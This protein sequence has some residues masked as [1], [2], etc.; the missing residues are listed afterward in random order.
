[1]NRINLAIIALTLMASCHSTPQ[2]ETSL[3]EQLEQLTPQVDSLMSINNLTGLSIAVIDDYQI[4]WNQE[5]GF[6]ENG[7]D[8]VINEE[9]AYSTAS[10]SKAITATTC[11][12][13]EE[14][15]KIDINR[16]VRNY[17]KR[18]SLPESEYLD[19]TDLTIKHLLS[20]TGGASH[21]GY[22][23]F[24]GNDTIPNLL[25]IVNGQKLPNYNEGI[26]ILFEPG[27]N[28]A[29]SG[30]GFVIVQMALEDA[31]N[32][33]FKEIVTETIFKPLEM[34]FTTLI[35][36]NEAG[37]PE[38]VAKVHNV[39][40]EVIRTGLPICPQ[41][42]PSGT[43]STAKDLALLGIETQKALNGLD[44]KVISESVAGKLS[45][46]VTYKYMAG[47][48]LGWQRSFAFG[49]IEWLT[50]MGSNT[51][52][53]GEVNVSMKD[54]RGIVM[55]ANG[56]QKNRL[57]VLSYL[58]SA[59]I[60]KL[61]WQ[62]SITETQVPLDS[63][64]IK[65][66][67][68]SYLD[69]LLGDFEEIVS[70]KS[71]Q[72]GLY[73]SS[74]LLKLI[75]GSEK[76]KMYHLGDHVFKVDDYPN[77]I[78]FEF[79]EEQLSAVYIYRSKNEAESD[80]LRI[81]IEDIKTV[82]VNL[83]DAFSSDSIDQAIKNYELIKDANKDYDFTNS[84]YQLGIMFY[85]RGDIE[86]SIKVLEYGTEDNPNDVYSRWALAEIHERIGNQQQAIENF[87][88]LLPILTDE[89]NKKEIMNK[90]ESLKNM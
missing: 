15:G 42:A 31:L 45:E 37:F 79:D 13:L 62:Q 24:Y 44:T 72:D 28:V 82:K 50:I 81:P 38:N 32:K 56:D 52:V 75:T 23:D 12:I 63:S 3:Y 76:K 4:V 69:F 74:Q 5:Y 90:I 80:K 70:I 78:E 57:P 25:E 21:S 22:A 47:G 73:L 19:Q 39:K 18:W 14:Q 17:L 48:A 60:D 53:G 64:Q 87:E 36:P 35:Q 66:L 77:Y 84:L 54:G 58:R 83:I 51:G 29:Y 71:E 68:G 7:T 46:I 43:W 55:L 27:T 9:T 20:H 41:L 33:S 11:L 34:N 67:V 61:D 85:G 6:K 2:K 16:P 10:I 1:M 30:G 88:K 26:E 89:E 49:N 59:V 8:Q 65:S 86:K 40:Q